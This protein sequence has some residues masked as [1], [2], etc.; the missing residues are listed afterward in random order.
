MAPKRWEPCRRHHSF[1]VLIFPKSFFPRHKNQSPNAVG[2]IMRNSSLSESDTCRRPIPVEYVLGTTTLIRT[3]SGFLWGLGPLPTRTHKKISSST[4]RS[5]LLAGS[6]AS[7][8]SIEG[9]FL[10]LLLHRSI[11]YSYILC[12]CTYSPFQKRSNPYSEVLVGVLLF[13][14]SSSF[15]TVAASLRNFLAIAY[16]N[17]I[18]K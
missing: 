12:T 1:Q 4:L 7:P 18:P 14:L 13:L 3:N 6:P 9:C 16:T 17:N 8:L 15:I 11:I 2:L 10:Q 5:I